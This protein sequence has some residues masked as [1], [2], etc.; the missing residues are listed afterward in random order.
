MAEDLRHVDRAAANRV[1]EHRDLVRAHEMLAGV[2][3]VG[4]ERPGDARAAELLDP[5]EHLD[6]VVEAGGGVVLD[7][8]GPHHELGPA[9]DA[10]QLADPAQILDP[11]AVEVGHVAAVVDDPLGVRLVESDP[12]AMGESVFLTV[13]H[14]VSPG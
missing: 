2:G 10:G 1:D 9:G 11:G 13:G 5:H 14:A 8:L 6:L 3:P 4:I 12:D 7:V